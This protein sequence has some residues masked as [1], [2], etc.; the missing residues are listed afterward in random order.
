MHARAMALRLLAVGLAIRL[1]ACPG[2]SPTG[3]DYEIEVLVEPS[4]LNVI[5]GR[6]GTAPIA[7][8]RLGG[9]N[10]AV[11]LTVE[12]EAILTCPSHRRRWLE[13]AVPPPSI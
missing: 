2:D 7:L 3:T 11:S 13:P 4:A 9:Y 10:G 12:G 8:R 1:A 6:S 5:A